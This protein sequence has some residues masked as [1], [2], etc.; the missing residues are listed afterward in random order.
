M[1]LRSTH[2]PHTTT[3][4]LR[5]GHDYFQS[6]KSTMSSPTP[7]K[8]AYTGPSVQI[9]L[10]SKTLATN[11]IKYH[12]HPNSDSILD[13]SN[14]SLLEA[15]VRDPSQRTQILAQEGIDVNGPLEGKQVGLA[16]YAVWAHGKNKAE[17]GSVLKEE[18]VELLRRWFESGKRNV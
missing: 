4:F 11:I 14:L 7:S 1:V 15:F 2:Q 9:M 6:I 17:G 13:D 18:D 16:A 10:S 8:V 12:N 5:L 3:L